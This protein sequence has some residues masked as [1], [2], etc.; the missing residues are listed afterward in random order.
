MV[1]EEILLPSWTSKNGEDDVVWNQ[2]IKQWMGH[3]YTVKSSDHHNETGMYQTN[4][5][6]VDESGHKAFLKEHLSVNMPAEKPSVKLE[7]K[8]VKSGHMM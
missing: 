3:T 2:G 7:V 6:L 1:S 8:N 4:V 5:Y